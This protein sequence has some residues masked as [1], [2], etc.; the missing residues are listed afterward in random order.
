MNWRVILISDNNFD[1]YCPHIVHTVQNLIVLN[2][3]SNRFKERSLNS[4]ETSKTFHVLELEPNS[5]NA[6]IF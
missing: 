3:G 6:S 1:G 5:F 4:L 2:L